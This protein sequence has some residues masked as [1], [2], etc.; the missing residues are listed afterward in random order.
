MYLTLTLV[1]FAITW[2]KLRL[3]WATFNYFYTVWSISLFIWVRIV[4]LCHYS[5]HKM[6]SLG[7]QSQTTGCNV[8][9]SQTFPCRRLRLVTFLWGICMRQIYIH[10]YIQQ[11]YGPTR[12]VK[13]VY[14]CIP[15]LS[16]S[17]LEKDVVCPNRKYVK[18]SRPKIP[19]CPRASGPFC[20][21]NAFITFFITC[22][23]WTATCQSWQWQ[24]YDEIGCTNFVQTAFNICTL[25][26]RWNIWIFV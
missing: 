9:H 3:R 4:Y 11:N 20:I 14:P 15:I 21:G 25:R 17:T 16:C 12:C 23:L 5:F 24:C 8:R 26:P 6:N 19:G 1:S 18:C 13:V 22:L 2:I 7:E 10:T